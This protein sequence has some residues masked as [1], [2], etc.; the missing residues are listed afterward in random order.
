MCT[1]CRWRKVLKDDLTK[2]LPLLQMSS[3]GGQN[4]VNQLQE[5]NLAGHWPVNSSMVVGAAKM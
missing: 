3:R 2:A 1:P 5:S 4:V